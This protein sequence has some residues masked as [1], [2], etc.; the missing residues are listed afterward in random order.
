VI[1][2]VA[3]DERSDANL[4]LL[5][6]KRF[7]FSDDDQ[8]CVMFGTEGNSWVSMGDPIG[9][10]ASSDDAAWKFVEACDQQGVWPVFYQ[11]DHSSLGRYIEMGMSMLKLGEEARVPLATC[12]LD[13][14]SRNIRRINRKSIE[15]GLTFQVVP[16]TSVTQWMPQLKTISTAWLGE[17]STAE[18]GFSLGLFEETYLSNFDVALIMQNEKPVAFANIWKAADGTELSPDLM[19]YFPD[20]P[21]GVMEFLFVQMML[22]GKDQGYAWFS[23]GMA[24]LSGVDSRRLGPTWNRVSSLMYRHGEHFYNFQ[25]LRGYKEKF[26]PQW[27]PRYLA[28]PGGIA[29]PQI[30]TNVSTLI[31]GGL[32]G[33]IKR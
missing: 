33:L 18:K 16:R 6:D 21:R 3:T 11:V 19:R 1:E 10:P 7:I 5:G 14:F 4:A 29:T 24:P 8:A 30:L 31:S 15:A 9:L 32:M 2:I 25:G 12:S 13:S 26:H 23:L 17:K 28:S 22:W 20:A 27:F